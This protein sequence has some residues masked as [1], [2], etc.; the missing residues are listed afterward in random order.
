MNIVRIYF[1][2]KVTLFITFSLFF[3]VFRFLFVVLQVI[4]KLY[5]LAVC[6]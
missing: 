4:K 3:L 5:M 2:R 6:P 1:V